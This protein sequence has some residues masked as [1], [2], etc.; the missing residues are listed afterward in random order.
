MKIIILFLL[1]TI[2]NANLLL[3]QIVGGQAIDI[4][5]AP[6]QVILNGGDCGGVI[7]SNE[8]VL[9]AAHCVFGGGDFVILA[10]STDRTDDSEG[11]E[12][13]VDEVIIHPDRAVVPTFIA[14]MALLHLSQPLIFNDRVQPIVY[15]SSQNTNEADIAPGTIVQITGWG[16]TNTSASLPDILQGATLPIISNEDA[17]AMIENDSQGNFE[18]D[19]SMISFFDP[20]VH[21]NFGDSGGPAVIF[22]HGC[23]ILIGIAAWK[24]GNAPHVSIY[25]NVRYLSDFIDEHVTEQPAACECI[26]DYA[27]FCDHCALKGDIYITDE[28]AYNSDKVIDGNIYVKSG[29]ILSIG[30]DIS[31]FPDKGII[32][33][34]VPNLMYMAA[35]SQ[36]LV[37]I[38]GQV[39]KYGVVI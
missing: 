21:A 23:P 18:I 31:F 39:S 25:S 2:S 28:V 26:S 6:Y 29:G 15:A 30:A 9:T 16:Q 8:W 32:V 35:L 24:G 19:N 17:F 11:Q 7:L 1:F 22:L 13:E 27:Y 12:I 14:D 5:D 3:A 38:L 36:V 10:G 33:E 4:L 20:T 34:R 37:A